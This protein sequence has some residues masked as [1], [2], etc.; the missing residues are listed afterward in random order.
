MKPKE[1]MVDMDQQA[2]KLLFI[3]PYDTPGFKSHWTTPI[4]R[5]CSPS[6]P[7]FFNHVMVQT[8]EGKILDI[9]T[10]NGLGVYDAHYYEDYPLHEIT[11]GTLSSFQYIK[12]FDL[13][14]SG[15]LRRRDKPHVFRAGLRGLLGTRKR[16]LDCIFVTHCFLRIAGLVDTPV[17]PAC[18]TPTDYYYHMRRQFRSLN[19]D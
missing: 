11:V 8:R 18:I 9:N 10:R 19:P 14:W 16:A 12:T 17:P 15:Y 3:A 6:T 1:E 7:L 2:V 5:R 13:F 4:L